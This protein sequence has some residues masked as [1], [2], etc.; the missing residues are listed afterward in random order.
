MHRRDGMAG[1]AG[2]LAEGVT[3]ATGDRLPR[4]PLGAEVVDQV[5]DLISV[6]P[7]PLGAWSPPGLETARS[8]VV[9]AEKTHAVEVPALQQELA[10]IDGRLVNDLL[11][12]SSLPPKIPG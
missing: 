8:T 10:A 5:E 1:D 11:A 12:R 3:D 7:T 4:Q 2:F 9:A 6:R